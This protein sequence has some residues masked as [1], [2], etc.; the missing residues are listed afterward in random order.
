MQD[1]NHQAT[2]AN[3]AA[4]RPD[5]DG[6]AGWQAYMERQFTHLHKEILAM[7][8]A[9]AQI[10]QEETDLVTAV[11]DVVA[12]FESDA[13]KIAQL[14]QTIANGG[15]VSQAEVQQLSEGFTDS[16]GKLKALLPTPAPTGEG[17]APATDQPKPTKT[18]YEFNGQG[19]PDASVWP[20][21]GFETV[22][23]EGETAKPLYYFSGDTSP[24]DTNGQGQ[25]GWTVYTGAIQPVPAT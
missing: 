15:T 22:P 21:S 13:A 25:A 2:A 3:I 24:T 10:A 14:E 5:E 18:V 11:E 17:E 4:R 6:S 16:I 23:G 1:T 9:L 8:D 20:P 7:T 19:T 12:L